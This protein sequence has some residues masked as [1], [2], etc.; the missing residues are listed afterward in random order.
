MLRD[1]AVGGPRGR[2][3]RREPG[4]RGGR[5]F[6][7]NGEGLGRGILNIL[8]DSCNLASANADHD[9]ALLELNLGRGLG[10]DET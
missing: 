1:F 7:G 3:Q 5:N 10:R 8:Q 6:I 2:E 4:S 9:S